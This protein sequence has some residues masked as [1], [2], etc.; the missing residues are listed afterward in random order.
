MNSKP[1]T[2]TGHF[3]LQTITSLSNS[4]CQN[5]NELTNRSTDNGDIVE[6]AKRLWVSEGVS[7]W[8]LYNCSEAEP[9]KIRLFD[10]I[11]KLNKFFV[12]KSLL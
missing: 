7:L 6:K 10:M 8:H 1:P 2:N 4:R 12:L 11:P 9:L 3:T 5:R